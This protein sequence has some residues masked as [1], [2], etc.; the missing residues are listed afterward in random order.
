VFCR[1]RL[2]P[3]VICSPGF[4]LF[5]PGFSTLSPG[6]FGQNIKCLCFSIMFHHV[7]PL[8]FY[9]VSSSRFSGK[10]TLRQSWKSAA[11]PR[12]QQVASVSNRQRLACAVHSSTFQFDVGG[13]S[14]QNV[15]FIL[16]N[17]RNSNGNLTCKTTEAR[18]KIP[19]KD[20]KTKLTKSYVSPLF[21][22]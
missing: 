16:R 9:H 4:L 22:W 19:Q 18:A 3:K 17:V 6:S 8:K 14:A 5:S 15:E 1:N 2:F 11:R 21:F 20:R 13:T 12:L 7:P 10:V